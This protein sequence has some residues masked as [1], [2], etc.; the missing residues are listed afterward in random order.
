[1]QEAVAMNMISTHGERMILAKNSGTDEPDGGTW[2]R[3]KSQRDSRQ[4]ATRWG[5]CSN[6]PSNP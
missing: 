1:M 3:L 4:K 6:L 5:A 2:G